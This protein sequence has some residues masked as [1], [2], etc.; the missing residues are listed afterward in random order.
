M[1]FCQS[2]VET[3][4]TLGG[5]SGT[6]CLCF[7]LA[8]IFSAIPSIVNWLLHTQARKEIFAEICICLRCIIPSRFPSCHCTFTGS[9]SEDKCGLFYCYYIMSFLPIAFIIFISYSSC[10]SGIQDITEAKFVG[11]NA[12]FNYIIHAVRVSRLWRAQEFHKIFF[13]S[14]EGTAILKSKNKFRIKIPGW[15]NYVNL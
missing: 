6:R 8:L 4:D 7:F 15:D 2:R 13:R 1:S 14:Q 11:S 12:I 3:L 5:P 10:I 9:S